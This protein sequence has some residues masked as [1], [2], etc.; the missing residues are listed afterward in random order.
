MGLASGMAPRLLVS[1]WVFGIAALAA[2]CSGLPSSGPTAVDIAVNENSEVV[3]GGYVIVD[4]DERVASLAAAQ[5]RQSFSRVFTDPGP[6]PDIRV[7]VGDA[8]QVLSL[9]HIS[10]PRDRTRSRMPSSA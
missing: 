3:Q 10:S 8:V 4:I 5:P 7:G 1:A 6:A 2:A 9:I